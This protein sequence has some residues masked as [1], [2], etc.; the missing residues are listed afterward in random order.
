[1]PVRLG[2]RIGQGGTLTLGA[3]ASA[4]A[5]PGAHNASYPVLVGA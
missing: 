1:M 3:S 4:G 5:V 2:V